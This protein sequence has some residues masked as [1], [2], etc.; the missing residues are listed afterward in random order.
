[1][2]DRVPDVRIIDLGPNSEISLNPIAG[3]KHQ[4]D[5]TLVNIPPTIL[6]DK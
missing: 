5:K 1:M 2:G 6:R 3:L 4:N